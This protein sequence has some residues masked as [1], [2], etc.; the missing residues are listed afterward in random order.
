MLEVY[1][2]HKIYFIYT[3]FIYISYCMK[4]YSILIHVVFFSPK[5]LKLYLADTFVRNRRCPLYTGL[6]VRKTHVLL[7]RRSLV[8]L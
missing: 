2:G 4:K 5:N 3:V 6:T 8:L 1:C 7:L